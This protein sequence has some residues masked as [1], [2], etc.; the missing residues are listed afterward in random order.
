MY[1]VFIT[2][3]PYS[4]P[5]ANIHKPVRFFLLLK[6]MLLRTKT[7]LNLC[8]FKDPQI[9]Q[10]LNAIYF[11]WNR[12]AYLICFLQHVDQVGGFS[13]ILICEQCVC[14]SSI[15][16]SACTANAMYIIFRIIWVIIIDYKL[17]VFNIYIIRE[18]VNYVIWQQWVNVN[19]VV[20]MHEKPNSFVF[21]SFFFCSYLFFYFT[22]FA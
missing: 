6:I 14:C 22:F 8:E 13:E 18:E 20:T 21:F 9:W 1:P 7:N 4:A 19:Y 5:A 15:V 16:R 10:K 2:L 17:Y 12:I 3:T 11:D